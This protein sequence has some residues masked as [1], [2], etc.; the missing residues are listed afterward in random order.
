MKKTLLFFAI[1]FISFLQAQLKPVMINDNLSIL[2]RDESWDETAVYHKGYI[3]Y[4]LMHEGKIIR[5]NTK[6]NSSPIEIILDNTPYVSDISVVGVSRRN[7]KNST[8]T[9]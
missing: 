7:G 6:I 4:G 2:N 5:V 1:F 8:L 9:I 3:Y